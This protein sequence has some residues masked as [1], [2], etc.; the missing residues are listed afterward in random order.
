VLVVLVP[1]A[2]AVHED[3]LCSTPQEKPSMTTSLDHAD[4]RVEELFSELAQLN[5]DDPRREDLRTEL[6]E[7]HIPIARFIARKYARGSEPVQDIEQAA[8]LGLVKA[9]NR[10]DPARGTPFLAYAMPTMTGEVKRHF[11]D[12][13]WGLRM[14]RRL[15]ELRLRLRTA[16][17]DF[18]REH[19]RA[20][21][22]PEIAELV[23]L[24]QMHV[25]RLIKSTLRTLR[26]TLLD[27]A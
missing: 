27:D 16:R 2:D 22:V 9:M 14:P 7:L 24:S 15:Q 3:E 20:P 5:Q 18:T 25:S 21:T 12:R 4:G 11:R 8:M 17:Q 23:G 1:A 26:L 10:F 19:G 6:V 13:T